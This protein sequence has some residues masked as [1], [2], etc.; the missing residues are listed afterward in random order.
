MSFPRLEWNIVPWVLGIFLFLAL[1]LPQPAGSQE[2]PEGEEAPQNQDAAVKEKIQFDLLQ[3]TDRILTIKNDIEKLKKEEY[4]QEV[5]DRLAQ[6]ETELAKLNQSF[7]T[8]ATRL[9]EEELPQKEE[10][11]ID[12]GKELKELTKPLFLAIREVTEKPRKID[13]LKSRIEF[14]ER[15]L[16]RY[17][18]T[19]AR[20]EALMAVEPDLGADQRQLKE[21]YREQLVNLKKKYDPEIVKLELAEARRNLQSIQSGDKSLWSFMTS[22][23]GEFFRVRGRNLLISLATFFGLWWLLNKVYHLLTTRTRL[24]LY[25][26]PQLR[27]LVKTIY[28]LFILG[29]CTLAALLALYF[30]DDWLLLS[31]I[32][33]VLMAVAWTS[34]Q[35]VPQF[36]KELRMMMNLS[37]VREGERLVWKGVPFL[38]R[39]I[40]FYATLINKRLSGGIIKLPVGELIG[41]HSRPVVEGEP[42]FPTQTGDWAMLEDGTLGHVMTQTLEQVIVDYFGSLKYYSTQDF[43]AQKPRNLSSGFYLFMEFGLDYSVQSRICEELPRLFED[44]LNHRLDA[45][46]EM[47]PPAI[48]SLNVYFNQ[49]AASSLNL[50]SLIKVN[51][52]Y[53]GEYYSLRRAVNKAMVDI[54]NEHHLTIPFTQL[55]LSLSPELKDATLANLKPPVPGM[56]PYHPA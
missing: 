12:W 54:C 13:T 55:T 7:E 49:T 56:A 20:V 23:L 40:G 27:K 30:Q 31:I 38:V 51:G 39:E 41:L 32:I 43:L 17:E 18:E 6:L 19:R 26:N 28:N 25:L 44:G 3:I 2:T 22:S 15:K 4:S 34:R 16:E 42:W 33:I 37:T 29:I 36:L 1:G 50:C 21:R 24:M 47:D 8:N 14:L 48:E 53:A 35:L 52:Q 9:Q 10:V 5:A 45:Y 11:K 46:L